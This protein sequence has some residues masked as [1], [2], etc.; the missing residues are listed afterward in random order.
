MHANAVEGRKL[1]VLGARQ[2]DRIPQLARLPAEERLAMKAV[3]AVLPFRVNRYVL[4]ELIDWDRVPDD[5]MFQLTFPQRAMLDA[6]GLRA[7]ARAHPE[8][9]AARGPRGRGAAHPDAHEPA[10]GG[11]AL[12][13]RA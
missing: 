13:Q 10:P 5:P 11:A 7:R 6:R 8:R 4:D 9:R 12:A 1:E 2:L 3:A